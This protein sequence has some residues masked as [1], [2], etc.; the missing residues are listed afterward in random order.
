[1]SIWVRAGVKTVNMEIDSVNVY[2][3]WIYM[4]DWLVWF[5]LG[6]LGLI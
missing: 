6:R 4:R 2:V 5:R 3:V 1:M